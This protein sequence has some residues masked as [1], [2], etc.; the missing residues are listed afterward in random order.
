MKEFTTPD[1]LKDFA[2]LLSADGLKTANV[3]Y[4][5]TASGLVAS[6]QAHGLIG[7]GD[8]ELHQR[9][10][11]TLGT[12]G[13][14][15]M[16]TTDPVFL[17][18]SKELAYFWANAKAH[19]RTIY[20]GQEE[21]P[22][23]FEITLPDELNKQVITDAGGAALVLE[24]GNLYLLW[25]RELYKEYGQELPE[26]DYRMDRMEYLKRLGLAYAACDIPAQYLMLLQPS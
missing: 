9:Q 26:L 15:A 20:M 8:S 13:H 24:P 10:L 18:Q 21:T 11:K 3:W 7:S 1:F 23:V 4:H 25:L 2:S 22:V 5:G 14:E 17:T 6:I 16:D 19:T 12:I